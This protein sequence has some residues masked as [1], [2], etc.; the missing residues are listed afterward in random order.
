M[1]DHIFIDLK[2]ADNAGIISAIRTDGEGNS[3]AAFRDEFTTLKEDKTHVYIDSAWK[4]FYSCIFD[5]R[6]D[7]I[8]VVCYFIEYAW[9]AYHKL[10]RENNLQDYL[11]GRAWIDIAQLSW[12]LMHKEIIPSRNIKTVAQYYGVDA[13]GEQLKMMVDIYFR[14][15]RRYDLATQVESGVRRFGGSTLE[16]V[17]KGIGKV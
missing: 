3:K 13:N 2:C 1:R 15:M 9:T 14:T 4:G 8:I 7:N 10:V 5:S 12:P 16:R 11:T 6:P 17:L